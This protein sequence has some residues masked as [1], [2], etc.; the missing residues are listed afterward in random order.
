VEAFDGG[1]LKNVTIRRSRLHG[2]GGVVETQ[3]GFYNPLVMCWTV[4]ARP[5]IAGPFRHEPGPHLAI[6]KSMG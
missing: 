4:T 3:K 1:W 2:G 5:E 6:G